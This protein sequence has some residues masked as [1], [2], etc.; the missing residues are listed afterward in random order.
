MQHTN[1]SETDD[2]Q[3]KTT[4]T[5]SAYLK[6]SRFSIVFCVS[7]QISGGNGSKQCRVGHGLQTSIQLTC[8]V[9]AISQILIQ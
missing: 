7:V 9:D 8:M 2:S 4:L 3:L 5:S 1:D 6:K